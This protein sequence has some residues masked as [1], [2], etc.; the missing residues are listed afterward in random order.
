MKENVKQKQKKGLPCLKT[1]E[2]KL[3][4]FILLFSAWNFYYQDTGYISNQAMDV[5][6]AL[7]AG[8]IFVYYILQQKL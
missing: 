2:R 8:D 6:R 7:F 3:I 4:F 1:K 5:W